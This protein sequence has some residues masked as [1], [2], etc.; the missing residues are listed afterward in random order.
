MSSKTLNL[1]IKTVRAFAGVA[2][3][4]IHLFDSN[5]KGLAVRVSWRGEKSTKTFVYYA[6][7][8]SRLINKKI[9]IEIGSGEGFTASD[10]EEAR[11]IAR[12]WRSKLIAGEKITGRTGKQ[13]LGDLL[14][15]YVEIL[16]SE[17]KASW[18]ETQMSLDRGIKNRA[19]WLWNT[20]LAEV[21]LDHCI[22]VVGKI[23]LTKKREAEK[24]RSYLMAA[25]NRGTLRT[26]DTPKAILDFGLTSNP[27]QNWKPTPRPRKDKKAN[28]CVEDLRAIWGASDKLLGTYHAMGAFR[29]FLLLGGQRVAQARRI[30]WTDVDERGEFVR[31]I[32]SKGRG[33]SYEHQVPLVPKL[34]SE[35]RSLCEEGYLLTCDGGQSPVSYDNLHVACMKC[36]VCASESHQFQ[37]EGQPTLGMFRSSMLSR[38]AER[39]VAKEV[40]TRLASTEKSGIEFNNYQGYSFLKEKRDALQIWHEVMGVR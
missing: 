38:L 5:A 28:L 21:E 24:L 13:T 6:R 15:A 34:L 40:R 22:E 29:V 25:F 23:W 39:G 27:L 37:L 20:P 9:P 12:D 2:G 8:K 35:I 3:K 10:L 1:T 11:A 26:L 7:H 30:T 18:R 14:I 33:A 31:I 17:G 19:P 16:K 4:Q 32:D 36:F